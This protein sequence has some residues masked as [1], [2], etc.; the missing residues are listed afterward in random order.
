[1]PRFSDNCAGQFKSQFCLH[2]LHA[3]PAT[4]GLECDTLHWCYLEPDHGEEGE[5]RGERR[6]KRRG[7]G[8][9]KG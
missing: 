3:A 7:G 6:G 2:R 4:L 1:M 9:R 5:E 8:A